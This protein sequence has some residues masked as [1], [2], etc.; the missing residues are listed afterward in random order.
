M[1]DIIDKKAMEEAKAP[2]G[3]MERT[4]L[5]YR[6]LGYSN[7]YKWAK[8]DPVAFKPLS[9]PLAES[10]VTVI[11]TASQPGGPPQGNPR[12]K[13][14]WSGAMN[15]APADLHTEMLAWDKEA[16]H[17]KDRESYLPINALHKA[18]EAGRVGSLTDR[19]FGVPTTYSQKQ[20]LGQDAP[21]ILELCR[22]DQADVAILAPM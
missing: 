22:E 12:L 4:R 2:I 7:D 3:Y 20:T 21:G 5:Y 1:T 19:F 8:N 18:L 14:V 9:Q 16:T 13:H 6:A 10:K 11:T 15:P 17:T